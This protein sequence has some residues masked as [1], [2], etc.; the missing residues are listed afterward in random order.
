VNGRTLVTVALLGLILAVG[1]GGLSE[2]RVSRIQPRLT[3]RA[4]VID[5]LGPPKVSGHD[6]SVYFDSQGR[7]LIVH[8]DDRGVVSAVR[9]WPEAKAPSVPVG[10]R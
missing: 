1:C 9:Y 3:D 6:H 7:Q 10:G 4:A 8:Y 2:G 5:L